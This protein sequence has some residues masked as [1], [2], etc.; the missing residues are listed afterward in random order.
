MTRMRFAILCAILIAGTRPALA[1]DRRPS[2]TWKG[3][4]TSGATLFVQGNRVDVQG[5]TTG[6]VDRPTYRFRDK[7]PTSL[8]GGTLPVAQSYIAD[9]TPE[10]DRAGR[11]G[12]MGAAIGSGFVLGPGIGWALTRLGA[13]QVFPVSDEVTRKMSKFGE[14]PPAGRSV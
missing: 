4:I 7:L 5:R 3:E 9:I 6:A 8:M 2:M 10:R 13:D 1:Q 14:L 12:L 11:M